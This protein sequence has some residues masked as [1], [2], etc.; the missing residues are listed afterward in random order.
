MKSHAKATTP[1]RSVP[2]ACRSR[3]QPA[4]IV[5][6]GCLRVARFL[7]WNHRHTRTT[8]NQ[9]IPPYSLTVPQNSASRHMLY[10]L[11]IFSVL[12]AILIFNLHMCSCRRGLKG[13]PRA[14][15]RSSG[16]P[17]VIRRPRCGRFS[18]RRE[19]FADGVR[20]RGHSEVLGHPPRSASPHIP[21]P[22]HPP[23]P[24]HLLS[25]SSIP[26]TL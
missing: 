20:P 25:H 16:R 13:R 7:I 10:M 19:W 5:A 1:I 8:R 11:M 6:T 2:A 22:F 15:R 3:W 23:L 26:R 4:L 14:G 18:P 12:V 9:C 17:E 21:C 24:H